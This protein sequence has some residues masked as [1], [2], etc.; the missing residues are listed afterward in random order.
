MTADE[1][2][3]RRSARAAHKVLN[4]NVVISVDESGRERVLMGR[5]IGFQLKPEDHLDP[6]RIEKT[7]I[8]ED[9]AE[10]DRA[11]RLLT[12]VPYP[13]VEAV[14]AAV[15]EAERMLG[16]DLGRRILLAVIDHVQYV[17]ERLQQG[18]RIPATS[19]P[20]LRVLFP[21]E[22][23]AAVLMASSISSRL[24]TDLPEEES[25]FLTMHLLNATRDEPNGTAALLFRRVQHVV[26]TVESG[27]GVALDTTSADY[28]RFILHVQFL[29]QRLVARTMLRGSDS[30]FFEFAKR[31]YPRSFAIAEDVKAYVRAATGSELTDEEVLYVVVHVERLATQLAFEDPGDPVIP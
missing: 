1:G 13:I 9:G 3:G 18:V 30:S 8:L 15:D 14:T 7:F 2:A 23:G 5:G 20:E 21:Q 11:R 25:V 22:F 27:L 31:S 16:R 28:A 26:S 10:G 24:G 29:L 19:M 4:N 6:A 17:L 12:D